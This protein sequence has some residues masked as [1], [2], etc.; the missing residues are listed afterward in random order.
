[1][2]DLKYTTIDKVKEWFLPLKV[3]DNKGV[4]SHLTSL[5]KYG[6]NLVKSPNEKSET[7]WTKIFGECLSDVKDIPDVH[8]LQNYRKE[9]KNSCGKSDDKLNQMT[10]QKFVYLFAETMNYIFNK[11]K[12]P[13]STPPSTPS[14][15]INYDSN[16]CILNEEVY[17]EPTKKCYKKGEEPIDGGSKNKSRKR[18]TRKPRRSRRHRRRTTTRKYKKLYK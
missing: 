4:T 6:D 17:N 1:M 8:A 12:E 18:S 9:F 5:T 13:P 11:E 16:G 15:F 2:S 3:L 7:A 10:K 14:I